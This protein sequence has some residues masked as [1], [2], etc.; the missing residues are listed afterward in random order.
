MAKAIELVIGRGVTDCKVCVSNHCAILL[1][2]RDFFKI[3]GKEMH[4]TVAE[5]LALVS[6][7]RAFANSLS[8]P[9]SPICKVDKRLS[10]TA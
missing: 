1:C 8:N 6:V 9:I 2:N 4:N 7:D 10:T 3:P 5:A